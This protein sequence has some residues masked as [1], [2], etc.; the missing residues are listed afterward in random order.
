M[1]RSSVLSVL[2]SGHDGS[3][4]VFACRLSCAKGRLLE[5]EEFERAEQERIFKKYDQVP[6]AAHVMLDSTVRFEEH[7]VCSKLTTASPADSTSLTTS[8]LTVYMTR[9]ISPETGHAVTTRLLLGGRFW[10]YFGT[11]LSI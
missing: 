1:R 11:R 8:S 9:F 7:A 3:I 2:G 4:L 10:K 5:T 6:P